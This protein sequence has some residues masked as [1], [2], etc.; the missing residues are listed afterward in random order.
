MEYDQW[1]L[2]ETEALSFKSKRK[3]DLWLSGLGVYEVTALPE[4]GELSFLIE[5]FQGQELN[6]D[7]ILYS[8]R[9]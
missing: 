6:K 2:K 5:I 8:E 9:F 7:A 4:N 3:H 1:N